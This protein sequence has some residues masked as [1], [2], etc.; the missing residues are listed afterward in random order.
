LFF[1]AYYF[2]VVRLFLNKKGFYKTLSKLVFVYGIILSWL[3]I[4]TN[5]V[6]P[7]IQLETWGAFPVFSLFGS[8]SFYGY[9]ILLTGLIINTL[10]VDYYK[11]NKEKRIR[12]QYFL[13]GIF[14]FTGL[15]FIFN[16]IL[17]FLFYRYEFYQIGNYSTIFLIG[18][19]AY[20]VIKQRLFGARVIL[21]SFFI[22]ILVIL[23]VTD[24][25]VLTERFSLQTIILKGAVLITII[26]FGVLLIRS[27]KNEIK[28]RKKVE[29]LAKKLEHANDKLQELDKAKT[30][31][32]SLASHQ[33]RT[34]LTVIKGATSMMLDG[35]YGKVSTKVRNPLGMVQESSNRLIDL[36][37]DF[38]NISRI[39][40]GRIEYNFEKTNLIDMVSDVIKELDI[41][42]NDK[43]LN[44]VYKKPKELPMLNID[45][46]KI[47]EVVVNLIEN[48]IKY[49]IDEGDLNI[50]LRKVKGEIEFCIIDSGIG[51]D[52]Q[53]ISQ[54]F[55]KFSRASNAQ[56]HANGTGLGLYV[57]KE[58]LKVH[59]G[60][61]WAK[62]K[63][64]NKGS[65]FWFR[66]PIK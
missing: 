58:I 57:A 2:F 43:E 15:N 47:R 60:S 26:I 41:K 29:R 50:I 49:N 46:A 31:F 36:V 1:I 5:L 27:V 56:E 30:T 16:V 24:I 65:K 21:A 53:E 51:I 11:S 17:P 12:I 42:I 32:L 45:A 38:L 25:I 33:L 3:S 6:I 44:L 35:D 7:N 52:K 23:Y 22:L 59:K 61:I 40:L 62:S 19:T 14:L 28:Q 54:L 10:L 4:F 9:V 48:A 20:A 8:L 63:G 37:E 39:E 55:K 66:L 13:I 34:P 64:K 18:F